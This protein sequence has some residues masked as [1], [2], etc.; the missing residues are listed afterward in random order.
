MYRWQK[1]CLSAVGVTIAS[2]AVSFPATAVTLTFDDGVLNQ[3]FP[4]PAGI[5]IPSGYGGFDWNNMAVLDGGAI[6]NSGYNNAIVSFDNVA[7]NNGGGVT[8]IVRTDSNVFNFN[9][10]YF[11]AAWNDGLQVRA[12]GYLN[13]TRIAEMVFKVN[14]NTPLKQVLNFAGIDELWLSSSGGT[15]NPNLNPFGSGV[16]FAMDDFVYNEAI[17]NPQP[18]PVPALLPGAIVWGLQV[19]RKQKRK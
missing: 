16:Q 11:T 3:Q 12:Q 19:V 2:L 18:I 10:A 4:N 6:A 9:S 17:P 7:Y 1:F 15:K 5:F 14:T 13:G 8:R